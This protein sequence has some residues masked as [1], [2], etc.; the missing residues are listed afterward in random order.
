MSEVIL[1]EQLDQAI[2]AMLRNPDAPLAGTDP[3]V[4][5]LVGIAFELRA[6]PR[7]SFKARLKSELESEAAMNE[8]ES[9]DES[10]HSK[11]ESVRATFRTV[12]PYL[13]VA[14]VH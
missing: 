2:E 12:T 3:Q 14:D 7:A 13:T 6:L 9:G 11:P 8:I 4:A 10:P 1:A 5:E